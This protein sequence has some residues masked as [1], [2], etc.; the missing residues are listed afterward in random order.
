[1][2]R[3]VDTPTSTEWDF[4]YRGR[5]TP[6]YATVVAA[7]FVVAH[8]AVGIVLR[9]SDT[10]V[11][12][13]V[14]DQIGLAMIG[15]VLG[16]VIMTLTL[17]RIRVGRSGVA[18]RNVLGERTFDWDDVEGIWYP[19]SGHWARLELPAFEHVPVMAIQ[20]NDGSRAVEAMDTIRELLARYRPESEQTSR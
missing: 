14:T 5:R 11:R 8:V 18:V 6:R 20:A 3:P 19:D 9:V 16:G 12:F 15:V 4:T 13:R 2:T 17:P 7:L 10:G 1:M